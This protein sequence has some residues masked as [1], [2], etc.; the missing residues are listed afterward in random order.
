MKKR[1]WSVL[2]LAIVATAHCSLAFAQQ[3]YPTRPIRLLIPFPAGGAADTIGRSM[4]AQLSAQLGQTIVVDNRPGAGGRLAH[5]MLAK[6]E[7]DGYTLL[8]GMVGPVCISPSLI[9]RLPYNPDRD[10]LPITRVAEVINVMVVHPRTGVKTV[11]EFVPWAKAYQGDIRFGSS[12]TGQ[13]DHLAAEL[14][15]RMAGIK[16]LHVPYKGG[17]PALIDLLAGD[18]QVMFPTY[19]VAAP[20][21]NA[22]RLRIIAVVS[23]KRQ[24]LL[25][26]LPAVS[27]SVPGFG[28]TNWNAIFAPGKTPARIADRLFIEINKAIQHPE[29]KRRQNV[30]GIQP[31]GSESRQAFVQLI[32]D[33]TKLWAKV[34]RD[35]NLK[36][37]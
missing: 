26:D 32:Q 13:P 28:L 31:G 11:K 33:E 17:G 37:E 12:G 9:S 10:L 21:A 24:P 5:E 34:I 19:V 8:V 35:A 4:G 7:P 20:H 16:M 22:G 25:P 18:L 36:V 30:A 2:I 3:K 1:F 23:P 27:E 29:V 14:F 15:Q 6:A